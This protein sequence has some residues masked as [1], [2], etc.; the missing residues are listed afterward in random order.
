M[1]VYMFLVISL[2][3]GPSDRYIDDNLPA[4]L[5]RY[6]AAILLFP[7]AHSNLRRSAIFRSG[8]ENDI[9]VEFIV[10]PSHSPTCLGTKELFL[11]F[12]TNPADSKSLTMVCVVASQ[13]S[14]VG[15]VLKPSSRYIAALKPKSLHRLS[16]GLVTFVNR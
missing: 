3:I 1:S 8:T 14:K 7:T 15:P 5:D 2:T 11:I 4:I 10:V 9:S 12:I 6:F 16:N 13:C